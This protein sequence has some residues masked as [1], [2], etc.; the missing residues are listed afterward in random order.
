[1]IIYSPDYI[2]VSLQRSRSIVSRDQDVPNARVEP[3][4]RSSHFF[5]LDKRTNMQTA[6]RFGQPL[7][8]LASAMCAEMGDMMFMLAA[9]MKVLDHKASEQSAHKM[10][11]I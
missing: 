8:T 10:H 6:G 2:T 11:D 7:T 9:P 3:I 5:V 4:H 1:M